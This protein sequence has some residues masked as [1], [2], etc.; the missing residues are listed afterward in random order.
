M[1]NLLIVGTL[2]WFHIISVIGWTGAALTFL[3]TIKPSLAKFSPQASGEFIIKALPRFVKSV[4]VFSALTLIFGLTLAYAMADGPPNA[5]DLKS[6]WS[7]FVVIGA[8]TG[9]IAFLAVFLSASLAWANSKM[10][11]LTAFWLILILIFRY[12][13]IGNFLNLGLLTL[14]FSLLLFHFYQSNRPKKSL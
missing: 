7:I 13:K 10:G 4:Q 11:F 5:F 2:T 3:V 14:I 1:V 9:I 6:L 8:V 12:F